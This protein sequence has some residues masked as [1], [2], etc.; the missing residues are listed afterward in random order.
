MPENSA[1]APASTSSPTTQGK[2]SRGKRALFSPQPALRMAVHSAPQELVE[3]DD[4]GETSDMDRSDEM[5]RWVPATHTTWDV[6][7]LK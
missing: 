7:F 3:W 1:P 5:A 4:W 2:D 6:N